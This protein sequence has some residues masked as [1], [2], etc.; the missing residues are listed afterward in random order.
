[1]NINILVYECGNIWSVKNAFKFFRI[2][3]NLINIVDQ[4]LASDCII[5]PGEDLK[6]TKQL[7]INNGCNFIN[8]DYSNLSFKNDKK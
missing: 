1:M 6:E 7:L 2:N 3:E 8:R 4:I 5:L